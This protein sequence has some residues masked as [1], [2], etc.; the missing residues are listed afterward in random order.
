MKRIAFLI[1]SV[2]SCIA[3][4]AQVRFETG[5]FADNNGNRTECL[6][7]NDEKF[8]AASS[9][10]Y[11]M[12]EEGDECVAA[13][14]DV[15]SFYVGRML[16]ERHEVNIDMSEGTLSSGVGY[17]SEPAYE[18]KTVFLQVLCDGDARLYFYNVSSVKDN[19]F[20][21]TS[22]DPEIKYL[23]DKQY[24]TDGRTGYLR[25]NHTFRNQLF[26]V[27][28]GRVSSDVLNKTEYTENDL[29]DVFD[30]YNGTTSE[31]RRKGQLNLDIRASYRPGKQSEV[32]GAGLSLEYIMP[33]NRNKWSVLASFDAKIYDITDPQVSDSD[34]QC[35]G[36]YSQL[37]VGAR[38]YMYL[39]KSVSMYLD[40]EFAIGRFD[41]TLLGAG[42]KFFDCFAVGAQYSLPLGILI[43]NHK[44]THQAF[45]PEKYP[46]VPVNI[47]IKASI[48]LIRKNS[49]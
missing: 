9:I 20:F 35:E 45:F 26:S 7:R 25:E 1:L 19:F 28:V 16:F 2:L 39:H 27:F 22:A 13:I 8:C 48:P 42:F 40:G 17:D 38:Y 36:F 5:W 49:K 44:P 29:M 3:G 14:S 47:Y 21:S 10:R 37:R 30:Q 6:I 31:R 41:R 34:R 32:Y 4:S 24:L 15:S 43:P 46:A 18:K 12:D 33:F 11:K 23:I